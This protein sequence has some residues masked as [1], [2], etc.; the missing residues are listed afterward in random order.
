MTTAVGIDESGYLQH[1]LRTVEK[2]SFKNFGNSENP[3]PARPEIYRLSC[4]RMVG[5]LF[6]SRAVAQRQ[7]GPVPNL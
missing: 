1:A 5:K 2:S 7:I 6:A 4:H 3:S